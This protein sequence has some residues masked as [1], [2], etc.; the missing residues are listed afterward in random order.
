[1]PRHLK[2]RAH[3]PQNPAALWKRVIAY[4]IDVLIVNFVIIFPFRKMTQLNSGSSFSDTYSYL[5]SAPGLS[6]KLFLVFLA[7]G[8]LTI[9]YW[10]VFEY[11]L[12]QSIGKMVMHISVRSVSGKLSFR[13][14]IIRNIS[15]V[16]SP[17]LALDVIYMLYK[18]SN[19]R[20]FE[21]VSGTEVV[22]GV[23]LK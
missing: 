21:V 4:L 22:E 15:K 13:S 7:I 18:R 1:M 16:S 5:S 20:Y 17:F 9:L 6:Y 2:S 12:M 3:L 8:V 19:Q 23:N 11:R 10:A 14:A